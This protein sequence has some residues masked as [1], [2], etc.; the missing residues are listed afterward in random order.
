MKFA[1]KFIELEKSILSEVTQTQ[2]NELGIEEWTK[3]D[4]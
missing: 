1:G 2:K 3:E 4:I